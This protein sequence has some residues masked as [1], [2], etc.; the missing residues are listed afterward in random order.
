M[1]PAGDAPG[2]I[3]RLL[4]AAVEGLRRE[5]EVTLVVV[6][7]PET[8]ELEAADRLEASGVETHAVRRFEPADRRGRWQRRLRLMWWWGVRGVPWRTAWFHDARVQR[9]IDELTRYREFDVIAVEDNAVGV[10]RYPRGV[11]AVLT[12]HEVR[13]QRSLPA[14]TELIRMGPRRMLAEVDWRRWPRYHREVWSRFAMVQAFTERDAQVIAREVPALAGRVR[15]SPFG[16]DAPPPVDPS[17]ETPGRILF[18]GNMTHHPNVDAAMWLASD[19]MPRIVTSRP[20][21]HLEIVGAAPPSE[22]RALAGPTVDVVGPVPDLRPHFERAQVMLAPIRVGGGMRMKV[23]ESMA[24]GKAVVTTPRGAEGLAVD[25]EEPPLTVA[26]DAAGLAR[27][28][29]ELLDDEGLRRDLGHRARAF[30]ERH[31]GR[32]AYARRLEIVYREAIRTA[33]G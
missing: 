32:D 9:L 28:T 16:I 13:K 14:A 26:S 29:S 27:A 7:G 20:S 11:P 24:M 17:S 4:H 19:L 5:H 25:G 33:S 15:V 18:V 23:L 12:E 30:A 3:P 31:H 21:A 1:T 6:A 8:W 22:L 10:Y 2:A